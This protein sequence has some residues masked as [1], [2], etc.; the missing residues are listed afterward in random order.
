MRL[1]T[2]YRSV[3]QP[4]LQFD[5]RGVRDKNKDRQKRQPNLVAAGHPCH[6][7]KSVCGIPGIIVAIKVTRCAPSCLHVA[8]MERTDR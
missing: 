8:S 4:A 7:A 2:F 1:A 5:W 6:Q 3:N